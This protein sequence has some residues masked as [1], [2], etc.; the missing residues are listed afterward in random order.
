MTERTHLDIERIADYLRGR[1][2]LTEAEQDHADRCDL[3]HQRW[4]VIGAG[5][6][7]WE[8]DDPV[9]AAHPPVGEAELIELASGELPAREAR[10]IEGAIRG[11][12]V[13]ADRLRIA[14]RDAAAFR[15]ALRAYLSEEPSGSA[16]GEVIPLAPFTRSPEG[17]RSRWRRPWGPILALGAALAAAW[18]VMLRPDA[19]IRPGGEGGGP[20]AQPGVG[21]VR[22]RGGGGVAAAPGVLAAGL[23]VFT[24]DP[25]KEASSFAPRVPLSNGRIGIRLEGSALLGFVLQ[26]EQA[27]ADRPW[28]AVLV[29]LGPSGFARSI[30]L[31][32]RP[33][34]IP[35][36]D[37][38][39]EARASY[40]LDLED[41][42]TLAALPP[43]LYHLYL[44]LTDP[45]LPEGW[46][47]RR[48]AQLGDRWETGPLFVDTSA[49][50]AVAEAGRA[51]LTGYEGSVSLEIVP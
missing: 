8:Q 45:P 19:G 29:A 12:S 25:L 35:L 18:L 17:G 32:G 5:M 48:A 30:P 39:P 22:A 47:R 46:L 14:R 9:H 20:S 33:R 2:D 21:A 41:A 4:S 27:P 24:T 31:P 16:S 50:G 38:D 49:P 43:G 11:C 13:C 51:P 1:L 37:S 23:V 44:L 34:L 3:C 36:P 7:L 6:A 28:E 40:G 15:A 10:R 26:P 42:P